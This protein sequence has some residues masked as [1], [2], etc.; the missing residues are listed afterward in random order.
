MT[1]PAAEDLTALARQFRYTAFDLGELVV[2]A[3]RAERL[4]PA[5]ATTPIYRYPPADQRRICERL[6]R[7]VAAPP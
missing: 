6:S 4:S 3:A 7:A 2:P 1:E 5:G